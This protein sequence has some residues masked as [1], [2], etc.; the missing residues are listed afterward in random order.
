MQCNSYLISNHFNERDQQCIL[1]T[2]L[3]RIAPNDVLTWAYSKDRLYSTKT[4]YKLGKGGDLENFH[5]AWVEIWNMEMS[6]KVK[7]FL[8]RICSNTLPIRAF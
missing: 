4:A 1:A 8:W 6:P 7:H 2:P 5:V 3:S